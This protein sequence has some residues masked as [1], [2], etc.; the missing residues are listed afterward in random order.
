MSQALQ[1]VAVPG[2]DLALAA[3]PAR[4]PFRPDGRTR[5]TREDYWKLVEVGLLHEGSRVELLEG[6]VVP[7]SPIGSGHSGTL[8]KLLAVFPVK[9]VGHAVSLAGSPLVI[10]DDSEPEPDFT[11]AKLR[12]DFYSG[13]HPTPADAHLL[14]EISQTSLKQD[15][16][17]KAKLYARGGA[18]EY[19]VVDLENRTLHVHRSADT[20]TGLWGEITRLKPGAK[21]A[22]MA[23]PDAELD[24]AW[25]FG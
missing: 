19:W 2:P 17:R 9:L 16:G 18:E 6:E 21:V 4:I 1:A 25:L 13:S 11:I 15:L 23:F 5:F 10:G 3:E 7:M 24:L 12:E 14:V 20:A 8:A 22:P